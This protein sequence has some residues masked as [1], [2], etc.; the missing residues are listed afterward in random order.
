MKRDALRTSTFFVAMT[1][2]IF[3]LVAWMTMRSVEKLVH[4]WGQ[5]SEMTI[6]LQAGTQENKLQSISRILDEYDSQLEYHL[7][8]SEAIAQQLESLMASSPLRPSDSKELSLIVPPYFIV[9]GNGNLIGEGLYEIFE[10]IK[11]RLETNP[12]VGPI[13]FGKSWVEKY[14]SALQSMDSISFVFLVILGFTLIFVIGNSIRAH[15][16]TRREEI[17]ILEL[18]GATEAMI[19]KPFL[20]EGTLV[21][22]IAMLLAVTIVTTATWL[23]RDSH[24]MVFGLFDSHQVLCLL[25]PFEVIFALAIAAL[26]GFWGSSVCLAELH[27]GSNL[28]QWAQ[29]LGRF[30]LIK[31][32]DESSNHGIS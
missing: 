20:W 7:Q 32:K 27:G 13:H 23:I 11:G 14:D 19:Q 29:F 28:F 1:V 26:I 9:K 21:S 12:L 17:E 25:S 10:K 24:L 22:S 15:I 6:F 18:V 16:Y 3:S 30:S 4:E 2:Y 31:T 5:K 8:S